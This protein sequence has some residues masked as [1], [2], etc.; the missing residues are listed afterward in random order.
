MG[1]TGDKFVEGQRVVRDKLST[2]GRHHLQDLMIAT[3]FMDIID[4]IAQVADRLGIRLNEVLDRDRDG[5]CTLL[6][7]IS[8]RWVE[9]QLRRVR[10]SN[11]QQGWDSHDLNDVT[12]LSIALPYCDVIGTERSWT[13]LINTNKIS[14][15]FGTSVI[16]DLRDLPSLLS[17]APASGHSNRR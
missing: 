14:Q 13:G 5:L 1:L 8:S 2:L 4:P 7:K 12:A 6:T 15:P 9:M 3:A 11:P 17:Q 16:N 10:Q